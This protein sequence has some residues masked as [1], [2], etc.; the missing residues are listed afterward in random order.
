MYDLM[1]SRSGLPLRA[2]R[3]VDVQLTSMALLLSLSLQLLIGSSDG[4]CLSVHQGCHVY[5]YN[6]LL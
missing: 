5:M 4:L 2:H 3:N 1:H 6:G